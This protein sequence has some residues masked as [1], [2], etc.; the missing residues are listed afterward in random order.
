MLFFVQHWISF[1]IYNFLFN[2]N[3]LPIGHVIPDE[4]ME[5]TGAVGFEFFKDWKRRTIH[6]LQR[7]PHKHMVRTKWQIQPTEVSFLL[8]VN[9]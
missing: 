2:L 5:L 3:C 7:I 8:K 1:F 4:K 9:Y 6:A